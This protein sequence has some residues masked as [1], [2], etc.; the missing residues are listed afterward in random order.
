MRLDAQALEL[1]QT[2]D[3]FVSKLTFGQT[4]KFLFDR[5]FKQRQGQRRHLRPLAQPSFNF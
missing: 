5:G 2:F 1:V 4:G 3:Q